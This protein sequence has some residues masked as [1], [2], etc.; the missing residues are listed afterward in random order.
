MKRIGVY[1]LYGQNA[2][3]HTS[4]KL[5]GAEK[6]SALWSRFLADEGFVVAFLMADPG[7]ANKVKF[8]YPN[9]EAHYHSKYGLQEGDIR[10]ITFKSGFY[11]KCVDKVRSW[12]NLPPQSVSEL[13]RKNALK[14]FKKANVNLWVGQYLS[15]PMLELAEACQEMQ[16]PFLL[17]LAH[18]IDLDFIEH[19]VGRDIFGACRI[20]KGLTMAMAT[21]VLVQNRWQEA[22]LKK[23]F[24]EKSL[25]YLPNPILIPP[26]PNNPPEKSG[27]LW[28][29]KFDFNKNGI[30][31][32]RLAQNLPN[33][34]FTM[35]SNP[36]DSEIETEI[37]LQCPQNL[38]IISA[39]PFDKMTEYFSG[40]AVHISTSFQEG[41]PNTFL[42]AAVAETPTIS[43][44]VD[45]DGLMSSNTLGL[46]MNGDLSL[47]GKTISQLIQDSQLRQELGKTARLYVEEIHANE[48]VKKD[49]LSIIKKVLIL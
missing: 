30:A 31:V 12:I 9:I 16:I 37:R 43:L 24:P 49:W 8:L 11:Q 42:E 2:F 36:S 29:G 26:V 20:K 17:A 33:I 47:M 13:N 19:K 22:M 4:S 10:K 3:I 34:Q 45:P 40:A 6:Q 32:L 46:F 25:F 1:S 21:A 15:D 7:S 48:K 14:P 5:G 39:V 44:F 23:H 41:F 35:I 38:K 18:D 28:V 27:V